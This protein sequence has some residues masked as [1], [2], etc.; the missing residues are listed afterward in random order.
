MESVNCIFDIPQKIH[1]VLPLMDIV[2]IGKF[3]TI[4][5]TSKFHAS[6]GEKE[7][8]L[9]CV[10]DENGNSA[11]HFSVPFTKMHSFCSLAFCGIVWSVSQ[12]SWQPHSST[13]LK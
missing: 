9:E 12:G 3:M 1:G 6:N 8:W 4:I 5:V 2:N 13:T 10:R 7:S 11:M